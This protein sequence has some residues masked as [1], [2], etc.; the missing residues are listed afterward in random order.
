MTSLKSKVKDS[1]GNFLRKNVLDLI[2][3]SVY[4]S[5]KDLSIWNSVVSSVWDSVWKSTNE[6]VKSSTSRKIRSY[7]FIRK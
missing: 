4:V 2:D 6:S 3:D 1:V 7:D 5:I